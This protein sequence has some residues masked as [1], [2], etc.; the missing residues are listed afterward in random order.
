VSTPY[1]AIDERLHDII[2]ERAGALAQA[3]V[4]AL[5]RL[6]ASAYR[7]PTLDESTEAKLAAL[8]KPVAS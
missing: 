5:P 4:R 2:R 1:R 3:P 7:I 6:V 8:I